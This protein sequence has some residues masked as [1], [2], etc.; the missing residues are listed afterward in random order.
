MF[1]L[2]RFV[3]F[4]LNRSKFPSQFDGLSEAT[5][6]IP[7]DSHGP[8]KKRRRSNSSEQTTLDSDHHSD[9]QIKHELKKSNSDPVVSSLNG[10]TKKRAVSSEHQTESVNDRSSDSN[11]DSNS[12]SS[13]SDND[14]TL[15][16]RKPKLN[17]SRIL[18]NNEHDKTSSEDSTSHPTTDNHKTVKPIRE[19]KKRSLIY[20][21][22]TR[23]FLETAI[24][25]GL[26]DAAGDEDEDNEYVP[27]G[28]RVNIRSTHSR[29]SS[30]SEEQDSGPDTNAEDEETNS[31]AEDDDDDEEDDDDGEVG[32]ENL[33]PT[34]T[35][36]INPDEPS[37]SG[38]C[39][40]VRNRPQRET[41]KIRFD[42]ISKEDGTNL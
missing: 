16:I 37:E 6:V 18:S 41:H 35:T 11:A 26:I 17:R 29:S 31:T 22:N 27:P 13:N 4:S 2:Y 5:N 40:N 30:D 8:S 28:G 32:A 15:N 38:I 1:K 10:R 33:E 3:F 20:T 9:P 19:A 14:N 12:S 23:E 25:A 7:N 36:T 24:A 21:G 34:T 42:Q 39:W